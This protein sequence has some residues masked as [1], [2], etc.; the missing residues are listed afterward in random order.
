MEMVSV[1]WVS[2]RVSGRGGDL[3]VSCDSVMAAQV[4]VTRGSP[5][6][7]MTDRQT[8]ATENIRW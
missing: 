8:D 1:W 5:V 2:M 3:H 7:R 6:N 4:V